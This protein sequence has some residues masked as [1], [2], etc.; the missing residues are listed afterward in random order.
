MKG[1]LCYLKL[2]IHNGDNF[3]G[4]HICLRDGDPST[5]IFIASGQRCPLIEC[6]TMD[7]QCCH[8]LANGKGQFILEKWS[9]RYWCNETCK[10]CF[11]DYR[12]HISQNDT[13]VGNDLGYKD[14]SN[15]DD[16]VG[17]LLYEVMTGD[18]TADNFKEREVEDLGYHTKS[19]PF[20]V[21]NDR[22]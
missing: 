13:L 21:K 16:N 6:I 5:S 18:K 17:Q 12:Y 9:T 15:E 14:I 7:F 20:R 22:S 2:P 11:G 4:N 19:A 1:L 3:E 10:K 8:E